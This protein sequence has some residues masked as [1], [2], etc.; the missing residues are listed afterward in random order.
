MACVS[1]PSPSTK[2]RGNT[3][4]WTKRPVQA[5]V[6]GATRPGPGVAAA[7]TRLDCPGPW[8]SPLLYGARAVWRSQSE[9]GLQ[10]QTLTNCRPP[11]HVAM[12]VAEKA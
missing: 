2:D 12:G 9:K 3:G 1:G 7:L 11:D 4:R 10:L 8:P 5:L 6:A